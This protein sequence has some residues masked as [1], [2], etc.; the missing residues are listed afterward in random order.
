[1]LLGNNIKS[2]KLKNNI[3]KKKI[4]EEFKNKLKFI[5]KKLNMDEEDVINTIYIIKFIKNYKIQ[6]K[7]QNNSNKFLLNLG[8]YFYKTGEKTDLE[9]AITTDALKNSIILIDIEGAEFKLL[10]KQTLAL[11]KE[12]TIII[13][14]H[15]WIENFEEMYRKFLIEASEFFQ[16]ERIRSLPRNFNGFEEELRFYTDENRVLLFSES[17]PCQMRF[18][19]LV[20]KIT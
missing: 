1:M 19:K 6:Y 5:S 14:V 15:N 4:N 9:K 11:M 13:E 16:F 17:R 12:A 20:P 3:S 7:N 18:L 10:N 2:I 8:E